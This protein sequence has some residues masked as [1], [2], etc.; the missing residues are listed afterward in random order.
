[1]RRALLWIAPLAFGACSSASSSPPVSSTFG[2]FTVTLGPDAANLT[3]AAGNKNLLEG[4]D[5]SNDVGTPQSFNDDAPPMT[6][7]AVRDVSQ[8][9]TMLFGS[10]KFADSPNANWR[11]AR[12][13]KWSG[14]AAPVALVADDGSTIAQLSFSAN[15][16]PNHLVVDVEPGNGPERRFSWGMRCNADD[17]FLGFG[18]Q[19]WGADARGETIPIW[20]S[21]EG[22]HKDM[23]TDDPTGAWELVGRRHSSY[24]ALPEFL[25]SRG[26]MAVAETHLRSTFSMCGERQDV[27]RMELEMPVKID[28]FYGP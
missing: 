16:D 17:H 7:F 21:E 13:G 28:L 23:T 15:D 6:G 20:T 11:V 18:A 19:T 24:M 27:A 1:M 2:A 5:A 26:Y 4:I 22:I 9:A 14:G 10:F 12:R 8:G 25:S 3:I